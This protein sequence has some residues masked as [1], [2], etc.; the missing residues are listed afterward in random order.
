VDIQRLATLHSPS[1]ALLSVYLDRTAGP[2][3]A[4]LGEL[5]KPIRTV[6]EAAPRPVAMSVR[7]DVERL[8]GSVARFEAEP[9]PT[10]AIFA[11]S[12]DGIFEL[13]PLAH[14]V[15]GVATLSTRPLLRPLRAHSNGMHGL[16]LLAE[17]STATLYR[18][19]GGLH[20]LAKFEADRGKYNYGGFQGY[21][22][23]HVSRRAEAETTRMWREAAG[24]ALEAHQHQPAELVLIAGHHQD[25]DQVAGQLHAYL[26]DLPI[27]QVVVDPHTVTPAQ[28]L[29]RARAAEAKVHKLRDEETL[30]RVLEGAYAGTPVAKGCAAVLHAANLGAVDQLVVAG[31]FSRPGVMCD[32]CGWLARAGETCPSCRAPYVA[33]DDVVAA[34]IEAVI[35][36]GGTARQ[37][38]VASALDAD[39]V[40]AALRFPVEG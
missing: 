30:R 34:A 29:E 3:S 23:H 26:R 32:S 6:V 9:A 16:I 19:D 2:A 37:V 39:G 25:L 11:S 28:L 36:K 1:G 10:W 21:D 40:A 5:V 22:E 38:A 4:V 18:V 7:T 24:A 15:D 13:H 12:L 14:Q 20:D 35:A 33:V 31:P 17:R 27:E 8:E